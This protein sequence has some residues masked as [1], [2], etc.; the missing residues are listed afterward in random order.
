MFEHNFKEKLIC[1]NC[2]QYKKH[3][4]VYELKEDPHG[5]LLPTLHTESIICEGKLRKRAPLSG[6]YMAFIGFLS[7]FFIVLHS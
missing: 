4:C 3:R 2:I 6:K 1:G 5:F 7:F